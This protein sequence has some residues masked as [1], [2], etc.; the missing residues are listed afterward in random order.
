[1]FS[2]I[3]SNIENEFSTNFANLSGEIGRVQKVLWDTP[4][5]YEGSSLGDRQ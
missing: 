4:A 1:M 3:I 2:N 5:C